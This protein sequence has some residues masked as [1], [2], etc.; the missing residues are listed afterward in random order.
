MS[1]TKRIVRTDKGNKEMFS[2]GNDHKDK[3]AAAV[4]TSINQQSNGKTATIE[5][6][7][8]ILGKF[9]LESVTAG[10]G[11]D[12]VA[13]KEEFTQWLRE[14]FSNLGAGRIFF[15]DVVMLK[16]FKYSGSYRYAN[17]RAPSIGSKP[18]VEKK[19]DNGIFFPIARVLNVGVGAE[20]YGLEVG[21]VVELADSVMGVVPN[22]MFDRWLQEKSGSDVG[23]MIGM[24]D[25]PPKFVKGD[26]ELSQWVYN[27]DKFGAEE[28]PTIVVVPKVII[29]NKAN[30]VYLD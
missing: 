11:I 5:E 10:L 3:Q 21:D 15:R 13:A 22:P 6:L 29:K 14:D 16:V 4:I 18:I 20:D 25:A 8:S 7:E 1:K 27:L 19:Q 2:G 12:M 24:D 26:H 28:D 30:D 23:G 9:E 17:L